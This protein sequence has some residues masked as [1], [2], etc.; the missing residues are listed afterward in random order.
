MPATTKPMAQTHRKPF[1]KA[2]PR[3]SSLLKNPASGGTPAM[4]TEPI[5]IVT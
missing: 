2:P 5:S 4:A 3:I 1:L